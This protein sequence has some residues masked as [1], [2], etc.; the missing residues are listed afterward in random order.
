MVKTIDN[1]VQTC[2]NWGLIPTAFR[3]CMTWEEQVLWLNKFVQGT[4]V[5]TINENAA[6]LQA[7]L[8]YIN[9]IDF[10]KLA[11]EAILTLIREG[12][13]SVQLTYDSATQALTLNLG[14]TQNA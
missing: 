5:P 12:K 9:N 1:D 7:A 8:D 3:Q 4:L 2:G 11:E 14:G 6:E 13:V 10:N